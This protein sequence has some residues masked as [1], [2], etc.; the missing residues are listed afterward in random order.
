[1]GTSQCVVTV[2]LCEAFLSDSRNGATHKIIV[3]NWLYSNR[4][5][6]AQSTDELLLL[7]QC[8]EFRQPFGEHHGP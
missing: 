3:A 5:G 4:Q 2:R 8:T 7:P 1:M 6:V